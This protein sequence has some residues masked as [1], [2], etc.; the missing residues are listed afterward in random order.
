MWK[1]RRRWL[2]HREG[3]GVRQ[4]FRKDKAK[5]R[6]RWFDL[7]DAGD[8]CS[9]GAEGIALAI[10][11]VVALAVLIFLF[12]PVILLGIDLIWLVLVFLAG[13]LGRLALG[14]PW[15]VEA[16][17]PSDERRVWRVKGYRGA[18]QLCDTLQAEFDAGLNPHPDVLTG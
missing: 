12:P 7:L 4:R 17:G 16:V 18:G 6:G 13:S 8:G 15:T 5:D 2:P 3:I 1:V 10:G 9:D 14:R 11:F